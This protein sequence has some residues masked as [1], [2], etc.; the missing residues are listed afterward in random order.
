LNLRPS[1]YEPDVSGLH[2]FAVVGAGGTYDLLTA[3]VSRLRQALRLL[4]WESVGVWRRDKKRYKARR[5]S[6]AAVRS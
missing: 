2:P 1:G 4:S 6:G 3:P 5:S